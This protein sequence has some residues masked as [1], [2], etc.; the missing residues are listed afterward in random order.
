MKLQFVG[1]SGMDVRATIQRLADGYYREDDAEV[2]DSNPI[3]TDKDITFTNGTGENL[4]YYEAT[5]DPSSWNDGL[6]LYRVHNKS[7]SNIVIGAET[8]YIKDGQDIAYV[9]EQNVYYADINFSKDATID[10]YTVIW[11]KNGSR[12]TDDSDISN[13]KLSVYKRD[14]TALFSNLT[15]VSFFDEMGAAVLN[16]STVG[17]R[18]STGENYVVIASA[19]IDGATRTYSW[20]LGRDT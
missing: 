14:G 10:K 17:Q 3:F 7:L 12:I 8:F 16:N 5:V 2:F 9:S 11:Y 18:Q 6:Y 19:D 15:M 20:I 13:V 4:G 1:G